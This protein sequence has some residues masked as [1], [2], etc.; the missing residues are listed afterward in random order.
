MMKVE[1]VFRQWRLCLLQMSYHKYNSSGSN[2]NQIYRRVGQSVGENFG[3]WA[4][5]EGPTFSSLT[6]R[7]GKRNSVCKL[8]CF[9][10]FTCVNQRLTWLTEYTCSDPHADLNQV[11]ICLMHGAI[12]N[13][14]CLVPTLNFFVRQSVRVIL[15]WKHYSS[16]PSIQG[17][18]KGVRGVFPLISTGFCSTFSKTPSDFVSWCIKQLK[19]Q[20]TSFWWY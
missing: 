5:E 13:A 19:S 6:T 12:V 10:G 4:K 7:F 1:W 14:T 9:I 8:N 11:K 16:F 3:M 20:N 2:E 18:A 15:K 17:G